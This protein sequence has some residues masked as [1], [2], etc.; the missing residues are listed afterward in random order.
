MAHNLFKS[1]VQVLLMVT[2]PSPVP[3]AISYFNRGGWRTT[4]TA[5]N[6][7]VSRVTAA[8]CVNALPTI[9]VPVVA[10]IDAWARMFPL[11]TE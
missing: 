8:V 11:K 7:F 5:L 2:I 3:V 1:P 6:V 10:V 4:V 9:T